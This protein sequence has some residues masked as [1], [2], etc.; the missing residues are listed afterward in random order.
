[1]SHCNVVMKVTNE[2]KSILSFYSHNMNQKISVRAISIAVNLMFRLKLLI[3][4]S[5]KSSSHSIKLLVY[6]DG[7]IPKTRINNPNTK[8]FGCMSR[9]YLV[10]MGLQIF[11]NIHRTFYE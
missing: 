1:M 8:H 9:T 11:S 3:D 10:T 7:S 6:D 2:K 5:D 4:E